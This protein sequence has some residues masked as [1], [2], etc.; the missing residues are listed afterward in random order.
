M[1]QKVHVEA[2]RSLLYTV[3][4]RLEQ[5][6]LETD[7]QKAREHKGFVELMTPIVKSYGSDK[8]FES[9]VSAIQV[10]GGYG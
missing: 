10:H 7:P 4:L 8:G 5:A 2:L 6:H 3:A 9:C 1:W